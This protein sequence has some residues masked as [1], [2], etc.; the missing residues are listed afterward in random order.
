MIVITGAIYVRWELNA[1]KMPA[2]KE[3][4]SNEVST[5]S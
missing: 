4:W 3:A 1:R 2:E 5:V